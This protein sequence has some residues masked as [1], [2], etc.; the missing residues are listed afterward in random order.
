MLKL[1]R[2]KDKTSL[3]PQFERRLTGKLRGYVAPFSRDKMLAKFQGAEDLYNIAL[4][5]LNEA[6]ENF[7][8]DPTL[9]EEHNER[10]FLAMLKKYISNALID[11]QYG[12]NVDKRKPKGAMIVNASQLVNDQ[13]DG[14]MGVDFEDTTGCTPEGVASFNETVSLISTDLNDG[15]VR[16]LDLLVQGYPAEKIAS[17][18]GENVSRVRYI[19]YEKIQPSAKRY[20]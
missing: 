19:I 16:V 20:V 8:Y 14:V 2:S 9:G 11:E 18:L 6:I 12:A 17:K 1:L 5:K 15:E 7:T 13:D 3:F 10:R 4:L